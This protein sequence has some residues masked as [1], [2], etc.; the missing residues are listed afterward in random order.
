MVGWLQFFRPFWHVSTFYFSVLL[1]QLLFSCI[2]SQ[3]F[4]SI[5]VTTRRCVVL[6]NVYVK[7][8]CCEKK[9]NEP[10]AKVVL[11][12][13]TYRPAA[14]WMEFRKVKI[15]LAIFFYCKTFFVFSVFSITMISITIVLKGQSVFS[16]YLR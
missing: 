7:W 8:H 14:V 12:C 11:C 6:V 2:M 13:Q 1:L 5:N 3:Y 16:Y 4:S 9:N 15:M 10:A